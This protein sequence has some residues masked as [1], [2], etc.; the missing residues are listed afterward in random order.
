MS[1]VSSAVYL[2][3]INAAGLSIVIWILSTLFI[4]H[5][6]YQRIDAYVSRISAEAKNWEGVPILSRELQL[7]AGPV[8]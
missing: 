4:E 5:S 7:K 6:F 1:L 3:D 2:I 8:C